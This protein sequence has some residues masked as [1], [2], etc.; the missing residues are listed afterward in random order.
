MLRSILTREPDRYCMEE[1][2]RNI[3]SEG[4][5]EWDYAPAHVLH[6]ICG[7]YTNLCDHVLTHAVDLPQQKTVGSV[8]EDLQHA[9]LFYM[10]HVVANMNT[11]H[12]SAI[13]AY[14]D[15]LDSTIIT[16]KG[17]LTLQFISQLVDAA[18]ADDRVYG[19]IYK[20]V[21]ASFYYLRTHSYARTDVRKIISARVPK[22]EMFL[23]NR[24]ISA[25][26]FNAYCESCDTIDNDEMFACLK[27]WLYLQPLDFISVNP[28]DIRT[29]NDFVRAFPTNT[30]LRRALGVL[31]QLP[32]ITFD[33]GD[34]ND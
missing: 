8:I 30:S 25:F 7:I 29:T 33:Y 16:V 23:T 1:C 32:Q 2:I 22:K 14:L 17:L 10:T 31:P 28:D 24:N 11:S 19:E 13:Y 6:A 34:L 26:D 20:H 15:C 3:T 9:M 4:N 27:K 21:T 18:N 12:N 5:R